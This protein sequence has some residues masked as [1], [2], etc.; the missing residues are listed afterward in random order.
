MNIARL[1]TAALSLAAAGLGFAAVVHA[2]PPCGD[3]EARRQQCIVDNQNNWPG[4]Q[5]ECD[6]MFR[7]CQRGQHCPVDPG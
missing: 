6:T 7:M 5:L 4:P 2:A 1:R 3:C